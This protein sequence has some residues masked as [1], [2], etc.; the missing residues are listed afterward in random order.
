LV[1]KI[2]DFGQLLD[3]FSVLLGSEFQPGQHRDV[4]D[5]FFVE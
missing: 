3:A 4:S 1:D 5:L 2:D